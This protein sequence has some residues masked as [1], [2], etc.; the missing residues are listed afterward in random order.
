MP[1]MLFPSDCNVGVTGAGDSRSHISRAL[2]LGTALREI[3]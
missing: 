2:A 1:S 3:Y